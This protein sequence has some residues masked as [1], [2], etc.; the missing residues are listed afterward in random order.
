MDKI[1]VCASQRRE[2]PSDYVHEQKKSTLKIIEPIHAY[3]LQ[4]VDLNLVQLKVIRHLRRSFYT[5]L[6]N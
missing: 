3:A 6:K 2:N 5:C 4:L 1:V